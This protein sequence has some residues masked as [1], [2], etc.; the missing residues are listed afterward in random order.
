LSI[1][2]GSLR[3]QIACGNS[4]T[5]A[6]KKLPDFN[7]SFLRCGKSCSKNLNILETAC[8]DK[9]LGITSI[10]YIMMKAKAAECTSDQRNLNTKK[11]KRTENIV[12][13]L[14]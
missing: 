11:A 5:V 6:T 8:K 13:A 9:V 12:A 4:C 7:A 14:Q 1:T 3:Q 2:T 10:Y